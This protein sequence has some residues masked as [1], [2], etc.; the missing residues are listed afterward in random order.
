MKPTAIELPF[1]K[2]TPEEDVAVFV[3]AVRANPADR[4]RLVELLPLDHPL[5]RGRGANQVVRLRGYILA[6]FET[7][8]LPS[9]SL[10][11]VLEELQNSQSPYMVAAAAKALRGLPDPNPEIASFLMAA[12]TNIQFH[13][14]ALSFDTYKTA[15]P[16]RDHT[17]ALREI[18]QTLAHLGSNARSQFEKLKSMQASP[19]FSAEIRSLIVK[20]VARIQSDETTGQR[21]CCPI[22][23]G[24]R[25]E[26]NNGVSNDPM[27]VAGVRLEDQDG[28]LSSFAEIFRGKPS[29]VAFFYTRCGNPNKC[30]LTITKLAH[31]QDKL[32]ETVGSGKVRVAA[33]TYD[34]GH[35]TSELLRGY[36]ANRRFRFDEDNRAWRVDCEQFDAVRDYFGLG[37]NYAGSV[38][39]QHRIELFVLDTSGQIALTYANLQWSVEDI[40]RELGAMF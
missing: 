8:G 25:T 38:V 37:A 36:C 23:S 28:T 31:L 3:D 18:L 29:V 12:I 34:P 32:V 2:A 20:T 15:W 35:D 21:S 39:S 30:S 10:I 17:S 19:V 7:I 11:F 1:D 14:D 24:K 40:V 9:D 27:S 33:I 13:D 22:P 4:E 26:R 16:L 6:S 5:Y